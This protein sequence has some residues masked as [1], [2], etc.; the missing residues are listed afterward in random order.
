V[1]SNPGTTKKPK[2][3][4]KKKKETQS[5]TKIGV[6]GQTKQMNGEF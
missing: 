1:S 5:K 6:K 2:N 3:Q 4:K